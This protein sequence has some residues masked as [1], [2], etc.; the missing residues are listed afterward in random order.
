M[1]KIAFQPLT[2]NLHELLDIK[3]ISSSSQVLIDLMAN[4]AT[5]H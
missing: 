2:I 3:L 4:Y 5:G 1:I